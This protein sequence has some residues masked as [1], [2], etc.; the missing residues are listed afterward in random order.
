[1]I[2]TRR[3]LFCAVHLYKPGN[4]EFPLI[5]KTRSDIRRHA[6]SQL[7]CLR[8]NLATGAGYNYR[9][10]AWRNVYCQHSR[11]YLAFLRAIHKYLRSG[12][13]SDPNISLR[14][15]L[16]GIAADD[17]AKPTLLVGRFRCRTLVLRI[18]LPGLIACRLIDHGLNTGFFAV[19][20]A[21]RSEEHTSEL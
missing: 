16:C 13:A 15:L 12:I 1:M 10:L 7:N 5:T 2:S 9:M 21:A 14:A 3:S 17:G 18:R 8:I 20:R 4:Q 6:C 19:R 11:N